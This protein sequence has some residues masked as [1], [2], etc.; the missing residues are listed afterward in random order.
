MPIE[1]FNVSAV[2]ETLGLK[3]DGKFIVE[4][5]KLPP[6]R[7]EK[8]AM[9]WTRPQLVKIAQSLSE[10][11]E[12]KAVEIAGGAGVAAASKTQPAAPS[13]PAAAAAAFDDDDEL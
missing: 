3:I 4:V 2:A 9:F 13:K 11:T 12:T 7:Q 6:H 5:L 10:Y 8:R 1:E